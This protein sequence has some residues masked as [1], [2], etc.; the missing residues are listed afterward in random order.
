MSTLNLGRN[1]LPI[2]RRRGDWLCGGHQRESLSKPHKRILDG[3][4]D[5]CY[6]RAGEADFHLE[7]AL[8][9]VGSSS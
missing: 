8:L 2:Q 1:A 7:R 6:S 5:S 3:F 9:T 4:S